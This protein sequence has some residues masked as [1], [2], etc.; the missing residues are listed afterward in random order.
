MMCDSRLKY[1]LGKGDGKSL[2]QFIEDSVRKSKR[3]QKAQQ[4]EV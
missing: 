1:A 4:M 2:M 3:S